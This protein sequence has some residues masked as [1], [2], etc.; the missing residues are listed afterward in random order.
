MDNFVTILQQAILYNKPS[1]I[2]DLTQ[3][4]IELKRIKALHVYG[5]VTVE[6]NGHFLYC[7]T[8]REKEIQ[9]SGG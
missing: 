2:R 3:G 9:K 8:M 4:S 5:P 1:V 7:F 6:G